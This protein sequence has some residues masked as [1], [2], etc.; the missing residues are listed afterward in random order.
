MGLTQAGRRV[1]NNLCSSSHPLSLTSYSTGRCRSSVLCQASVAVD[2]YLPPPL[3]TSLHT[4]RAI[5]AG[6]TASHAHCHVHTVRCNN[7]PS[8]AG[9]A[10]APLS[11]RIFPDLRSICAN[12][13][14][15]F[16]NPSAWAACC[17]LPPQLL[18]P[19]ALVMVCIAKGCI[20]SALQGHE[21]QGLW[22]ETEDSFPGADAPHQS[23]STEGFPHPL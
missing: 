6:R 21:C 15:K 23:M 4:S 1:Y 3:L 16:P 7:I 8:T 11:S 17:K 22:E 5:L 20:W 9:R 18:P 12:A 19:A 14:L 2:K 10:V 13:A